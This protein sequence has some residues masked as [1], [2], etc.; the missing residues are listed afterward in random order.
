[1]TTTYA[2][3]HAEAMA[4]YEPPDFDPELDPCLNCGR[5]GAHRCRSDRDEQR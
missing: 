3:V 4:D 5:T 1:M 2:D